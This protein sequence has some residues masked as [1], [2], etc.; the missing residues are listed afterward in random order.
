[1]SMPSPD[2]TSAPATGRAANPAGRDMP[3]RPPLLLLAAA[4]L[5]LQ[6]AGLLAATV[7]NIIEVAT[8]QT[9]KA[10]DGVALIVLEVILI[11]GMAG[12]ASGVARARPW[13]RTPAVMTQALVGVIAIYLLQAHVY[14][15]GVPA[16]LLALAGLAGLL[17]PASVR[18]LARPVPAGQ[19]ETPGKPAPGKPVSR[20]S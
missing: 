6:A 4:A 5:A 13:T 19:P 14:G 11:I 9:Y 20:R 2:G 8:G 15:W 18:A 3:A 12:I 10:A 16:L 1:M 17:T 7:L